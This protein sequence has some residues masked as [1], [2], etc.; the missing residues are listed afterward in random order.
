MGKLKF[1]S[2]VLIFDYVKLN[3]TQQNQLEAN[4]KKHFV[5]NVF[6]FGSAVST[7]F[8]ASSDLDFA[9][10]FSE[11]LPPLE[12]GEPFLTSWMI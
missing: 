8:S 3:P 1:S 4:C 7:S 5:S 6:L 9:F 11:S 2:L 10:F 12:H